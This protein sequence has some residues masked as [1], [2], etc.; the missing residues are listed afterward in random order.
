MEIKVREA[1]ISD[2]KEIQIICGLDLGYVCDKELVKRRLANLDHNRECV[3]VA[4]D[5][6]KVVGFVHVEVYEVLY[7]QSVANILGIAV[8]SEFRRRGIGK[9]LLSQAEEWAK[10]KGIA[11]MR[12]NTGAAREGAHAFYRSLGYID[13]KLQLR[14]LKPL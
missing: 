3:F 7:A 9:K 4:D 10:S 6:N 5:D 13:E 8:S 12:L 14:F 2:Y 1:R 11:M